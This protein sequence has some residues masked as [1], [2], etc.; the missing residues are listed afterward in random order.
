MGQEAAVGDACA[1]DMAP[2]ERVESLVQPRRDDR[3]R[4]AYGKFARSVPR[5]VVFAGTTNRTAFLIDPTGNRRYWPIVV[6]KE[7]DLDAAAANRDQYW[8]EAVNWYRGGHQWHLTKEEKV[9]LAPAHEAHMR[10]DPWEAEILSWTIGRAEFTVQEILRGPLDRDVDKWSPA[11]E[12]RVRGILQRV[13]FVGSREQRRG[14][15]T[16][17]WSR[18]KDAETRTET[19][20]ELPGVQHPT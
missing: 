10:E 11:D 2:A 17:F 18:P 6:G 12:S 9:L 4:A 15:R 20:A 7:F 8:A 5:S 1:L 16:T 19:H 13:G 3:F 14:V